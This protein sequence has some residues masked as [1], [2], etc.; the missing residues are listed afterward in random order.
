MNTRDEYECCET[1]DRKSNHSEKTKRELTSRL[2]RIEGQVRGIK[3]MVEKDVYCDDILNQI[4]SVQ[5]ALNSTGKMILDKHLRSCV[6]ERIL[7]GDNEVFD[8]LLKT[9]HRLLI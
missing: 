4:A 3:A 6:K 5:A 7:S 1:S 9:I 2:N 8:E